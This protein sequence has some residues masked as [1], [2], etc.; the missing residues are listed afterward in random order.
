MSMQRKMTIIGIFIPI[1]LMSGV[2]LN[3]LMEIA[4]KQGLITGL[5]FEV[6]YVLWGFFSTGV[7]Y[8]I[9]RDRVKEVDHKQA[10]ADKG[11]GE[12]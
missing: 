5:L 6:R 2:A 12:S 9:T 1:L 11:K 3:A 10:V 7:A 8:W 4:I